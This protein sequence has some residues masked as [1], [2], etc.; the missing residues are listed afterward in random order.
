MKFNFQTAIKSKGFTMS[1][2]FLGETYLLIIPDCSKE[3]TEYRLQGKR[4]VIN[5]QHPTP[6]IDLNVSILFLDG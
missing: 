2:V 6:L 3:F 1:Q 4:L 5:D